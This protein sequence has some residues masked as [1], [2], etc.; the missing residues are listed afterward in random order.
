MDGVHACRG[1][2][3]A[4]QAAVQHSSTRRSSTTRMTPP[5][6]RAPPRAP[7][8]PRR[9]PTPAPRP[10]ARAPTRAPRWRS[11]SGLPPALARAPRRARATRRYGYGCGYGYRQG[12]YGY[13]CK[14][15]AFT[16]CLYVCLFVRVG[17]SRPGY[18]RGLFANVCI[19]VCLPT[20][21]V[22]ARRCY[23]PALAEAI[24]KRAQRNKVS[25]KT[26]PLRC[27]P[28]PTPGGR[29]VWFASSEPCRILPWLGLMLQRAQGSDLRAPGKR[30]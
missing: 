3:G 8:P 14:R 16:Y 29:G 12:M 25:K 11:S 23:S 24:L 10:P 4:G 15:A 28:N 26:P 19:A 17:D 27:S 1:G 21:D 30:M 20:A 2:Q 9:P 5:P 13:V 22:N 7:P 6:A 18:I